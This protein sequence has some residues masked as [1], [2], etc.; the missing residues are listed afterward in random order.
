MLGRRP[1]QRVV[2]AFRELTDTQFDYW[3]A[4][5]N[6]AVTSIGGSA[7]EFTRDD[8]DK[9]ISYWYLL[10]FLLEQHAL[11]ANSFTVKKG[12]RFIERRAP[13][14]PDSFLANSAA[15]TRRRRFAVT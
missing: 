12:D 15:A 8:K 5:L 13:F 3:I 4:S 6:R 2:H 10:M 1:E 14:L 7:D 9:T 11:N